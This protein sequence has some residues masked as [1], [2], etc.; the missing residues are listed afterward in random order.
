MSKWI[1]SS[2]ICIA[3]LLCRRWTLFAL[4]FYGGGSNGVCSLSS[5]LKFNTRHVRYFMVVWCIVIFITY[6]I[7]HGGGVK[8]Y[9]VSWYSLSVWLLSPGNI[10]ING[11]TFHPWARIPS[12]SGSCLSCFVLMVCSIKFSYMNVN[13]IIWMVRLNASI[14]GHICSNTAPFMYKIF[15]CFQE[16]P[17]HKWPQ[18]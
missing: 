16:V 10:T 2:L 1:F 8:A 5:S 11:L 3:C 17:L 6:S 18:D 12:M 15:G 7:L 13:T 9:K 4:G 14:S